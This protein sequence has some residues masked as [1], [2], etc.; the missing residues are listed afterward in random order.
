MLITTAKDYWEACLDYR[1]T[2]YKSLLSALS[3][4]EKNEF[5]K[6]RAANTLSQIEME[7][8]IESN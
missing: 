1:R 2:G 7:A 6:K 3:I 8:K 5:M 4:L